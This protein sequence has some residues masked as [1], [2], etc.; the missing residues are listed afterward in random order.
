VLSWGNNQFPT[1]LEIENS[2]FFCAY[3]LFLPAITNIKI[4]LLTLLWVQFTPYTSY[5][6]IYPLSQSAT[7]MQHTQKVCLCL[8][9]SLTANQF[10]VSC[11]VNF[12]RLESSLHC[13]ESCL[14]PHFFTLQNILRN[15]ISVCKRSL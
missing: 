4:A 2:P 7:Y 14:R 3:P 12:M 5:S 9:L 8:P 15:R 13:I 1:C 10:F 11:P 6:I